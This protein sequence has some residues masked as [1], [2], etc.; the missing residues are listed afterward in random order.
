MLKSFL[1][2]A[3]AASVALSLAFADEAQK[4]V[5]PVNKTAANSGQ[6]MFVNY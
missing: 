1:A 5:V 6:E 3:A 4:I 2:I